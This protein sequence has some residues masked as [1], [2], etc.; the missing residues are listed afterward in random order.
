MFL[1]FESKEAYSTQQVQRINS[2]SM[3]EKEYVKDCL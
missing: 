1:I 2:L 3:I